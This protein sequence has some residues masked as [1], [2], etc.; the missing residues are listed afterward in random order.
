MTAGRDQ[1][2]GSRRTALK[3]CLQAWLIYN[4]SRGATGSNHMNCKEAHRVLCEAQDS[5]LSFARRLALRWHL[6]IC[7]HC[8]RFGRQLN[9]L[10]T[11]VRRYRDGGDGK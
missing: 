6:A 9:F 11:A 10:R 4:A 2:A 3:G 1:R 8:T 5:K 7:D